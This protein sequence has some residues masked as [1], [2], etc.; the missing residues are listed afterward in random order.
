M[1]CTKRGWGS[2]SLPLAGGGNGFGE[3]RVFWG[4]SL[5]IAR[6]CFTARENI[7][8]QSHTLHAVDDTLILDRP[9]IASY[10]FWLT[11]GYIVSGK[12]ILQSVQAT[13]SPAGVIN[14]APLQATAS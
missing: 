7:L 3:Q 4:N 9:G 5:H 1:R 11:K 14:L 10:A 12:V 8:R 6:L 2:H 13:T